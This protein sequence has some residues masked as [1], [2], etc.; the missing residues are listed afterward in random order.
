MA[1][2]STSRVT[3]SETQRTQRRARRTQRK[4]T[5]KNVARRRMVMARSTRIL[6]AL[7]LSLFPVRI[8]LAQTPSAAGHWEGAI[9]APFGNVAVAVDIAAEDGVLRGRFSNPSEQIN[10][11]PFARVAVDARS[12]ELQ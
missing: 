2:R 3:T 6:V 12:I 7:T 5:K 9:H 1:P 10:G 4:I 11:L 8:A